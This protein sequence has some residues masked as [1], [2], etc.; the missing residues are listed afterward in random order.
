MEVIPYAQNK[1]AHPA[2][3]PGYPQPATL[4]RRNE[5]SKLSH[6]ANVRRTERVVHKYR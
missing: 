6:C 1:A 4:L 3:I 5:G 2:Y